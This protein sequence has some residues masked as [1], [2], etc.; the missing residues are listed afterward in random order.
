MDGRSSIRSDTA[1]RANIRTC[2]SCVEDLPAARFPSSTLTDRCSHEMST[3]VDC[4]QQWIDTQLTAQGR[5]KITCLEC[6]E[7][8]QYADVQR[9]AEFES[10]QRYDR[11]A[12]RSEYSKVANFR[13]CTN[14]G[15]GSGQVHDGGQDAI[16]HCHSVCT[17]LISPYPTWSGV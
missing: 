3:C 15:C 9:H 2:L 16:F 8:L 14:R 4:V 11:L 17:A 12:A 5:N 1:T 10:F 6:S 7:T 13:W